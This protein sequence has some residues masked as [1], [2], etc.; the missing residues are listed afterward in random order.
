LT[1]PY[2]SNVPLRFVFVF[3]ALS[4]I[5]NGSRRGRNHDLFVRR[6]E[7]GPASHSAAMSQKPIGMD[8]GRLPGVLEKSNESSWLHL[9]HRA[10]IFRAIPKIVAGI[11]ACFPD[12]FSKLHL[13]R[14]T[15]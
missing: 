15:T 9:C 13:K 14:G 8:F 2:R 4:E 5:K 7:F 6:D 3:L 11:P 12:P 1:V 10:A